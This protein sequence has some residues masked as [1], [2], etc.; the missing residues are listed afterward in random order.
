MFC[1]F[2]RWTVYPRIHSCLLHAVSA[3]Y[4][5][6]CLCLPYRNIMSGST[7]AGSGWCKFQLIARTIYSQHMWF[8]GLML[9]MLNSVTFFGI[10]YRHKRNLHHILWNAQLSLKLVR[11]ITKC[12]EKIILW[13]YS[14]C[15]AVR[16]SKDKWIWYYVLYVNS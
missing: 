16:I 6:I 12:S 9:S 8:F 1:S 3:L 11:R 10:S 7:T 15:F 4:V 2:P 14:I 5:K 13:S